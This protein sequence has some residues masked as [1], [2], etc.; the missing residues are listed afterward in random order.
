MYLYKNLYS[1][2]PH[3]TLSTRWWVGLHLYLL[4]W[5]SAG[6]APPLC[7]NPGWSPSQWRQKVRFLALQWERCSHLKKYFHSHASQEAQHKIN[8]LDPLHLFRFQTNSTHA[9][10]IISFPR[11]RVES[12]CLN[13]SISNKQNLVILVLVKLWFTKGLGELLQS[14]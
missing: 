13:R 2:P 14:S 10:N 4:L 5:V 12:N 6:P 3:K 1:S 8:W 11:R 7:H 9:D